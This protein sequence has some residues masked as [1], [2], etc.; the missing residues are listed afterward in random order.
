MAW[1]P[2]VLSLQERVTETRRQRSA[3]TRLWFA[4]VRLCLI[5]L[6]WFV[7]MPD[8]ICTSAK[9]FPQ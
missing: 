7:T 3:P 2:P 4:I 1:R 8:A 5:A 6:R 9:P